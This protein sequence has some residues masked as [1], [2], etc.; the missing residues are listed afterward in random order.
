MSFELE[1]NEYIQFSNEESN[2][3]TRIAKKYCL[4]VHDLILL[5]VLSLNI[6]NAPYNTGCDNKCI[7][8]LCLESHNRNYT[9]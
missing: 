6:E 8:N 7:E 3:I 4:H 9:T 1:D 2:L 5:S